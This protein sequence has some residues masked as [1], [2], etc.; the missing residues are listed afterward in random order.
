[1]SLDKFFGQVYVFG[2][3]TGPAK[4]ADGSGL[5]GGAGGKGGMRAT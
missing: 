2:I 3:N 1:M 4:C 5:T